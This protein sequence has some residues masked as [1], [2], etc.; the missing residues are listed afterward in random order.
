MKMIHVE[1]N[2]VCLSVCACA[3]VYACVCVCVCVFVYACVLQPL[4][5]SLK[6]SVTMQQSSEALSDGGPSADSRRAEFRRQTSL[7]Q[8]IRQ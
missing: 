2:S 5:S 8:S 1:M 6:K 3:C 7:S 4:R